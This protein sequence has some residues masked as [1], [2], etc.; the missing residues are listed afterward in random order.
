MFKVRFHLGAGQHYMHWQVTKPDGSK[1]YYDPASVELRMY[2]CRLV[3]RRKTAERI[4]EGRHKTPCAWIEAAE[5]RVL[6][7]MDI[8]YGNG[9]CERGTLHYNPRIAPHWRSS[10]GLDLDG[11]VYP[12]VRAFAGVLTYDLSA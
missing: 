1:E 7:A 10:R 2:Q 12:Q 5:V 4:H 11:Y 6:H 8:S 3:N 9:G